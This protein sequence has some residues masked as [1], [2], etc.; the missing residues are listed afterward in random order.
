[1]RDDRIQFFGT[2]KPGETVHSVYEL[3][4]V[5]GG[6]FASP[7]VKAEAMY[8]PRYWSATGGGQIR[9]LDPWK[10]MTD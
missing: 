4:A 6:E 1:M 2:L 7:P 10:A 9:I 5:T 8:E 3:R